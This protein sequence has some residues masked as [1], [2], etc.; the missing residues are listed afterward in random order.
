MYSYVKH[1]I[2]MLFMFHLHSTVRASTVYANFNIVL[3]DHICLFC[4][5]WLRLCDSVTA[6]KNRLKIY[7]VLRDQV[8][9]VLRLVWLQVIKTAS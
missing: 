4:W 8:I 1:D 7:Y 6:S 9:V 5:Q 2:V 3:S